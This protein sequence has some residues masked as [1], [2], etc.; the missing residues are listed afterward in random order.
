MGLKREIGR[1]STGVTECF[2]R[3]TQ[4]LRSTPLSLLSPEHTE[5]VLLRLG[6]SWDEI[7]KLKESAAIG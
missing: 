6:L 1:I 2:R 4:L 5:T 3:V 7:A